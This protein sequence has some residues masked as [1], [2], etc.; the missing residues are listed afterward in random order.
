MGDPRR[1]S[2]DNCRITGELGQHRDQHPR[3]G[4]TQVTAQFVGIQPGAVRGHGRI[5]RHRTSLVVSPSMWLSR[6]G[7]TGLFY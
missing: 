3:V 2:I 6:C 4:L 7:G 5:G 1:E